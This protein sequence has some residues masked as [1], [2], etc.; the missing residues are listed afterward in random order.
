LGQRNDPP[1]KTTFWIACLGAL[2]GMAGWLMTDRHLTA[3]HILVW[4]IANIVFAAVLVLWDRGNPILS[5][6]VSPESLTIVRARSQGVYPWRQ[7]QAARFQKYPV[8]TMGTSVECFK[9]RCLG[10]NHELLTGLQPAADEEFRIL[11]SGIMEHLNIPEVSATLLSFGHVLSVGGAI[12]FL[13]G[14]FGMLIAHAIGYHT[15]GTIFGLAFII[16]GAVIALM[17]R[18]LRLSRLVISATVTLFLVGGIILSSLGINVRQVL[19]HWE[20]QERQQWIW[21]TTE[22]SR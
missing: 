18:D 1:W 19:N 8:V 4:I 14:T 3:V 22:E 7:M 17:T 10:R 20:Q 15:M 9:F 16:T 6:R 11:V 21:P 5:L 13:L 2:L 12:T